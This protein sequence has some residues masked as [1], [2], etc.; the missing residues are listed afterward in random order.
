MNLKRFQFHY[1]TIIS[2]YVVYIIIVFNYPIILELDKFF[3]QSAVHSEIFEHFFYILVFLILFGL[4]FIFIL[5]FG[6]RYLLKPI[7]ILLLLCS[8]SIFYF[9]HTYGVAVDEGV[10]L[11]LFDAL[12]EGNTNEIFDLISVKLLLLIFTLGFIP[13]IPL[14]FTTIIYPSFKKEIITRTGLII[15]TFLVLIGL[16]ASNY[17]DVSLTARQNKQLNQ[18]A[19]PHYSVSSLFS[20][21]KHS[22]QSKPAFATLDEKPKIKNSNEQIIGIVVVGETA[23]ADHFGINGYTKQTTPLLQKTNIIN[24]TNAYSCGTLTKISVPC[25]F[26]LKNYDQFDVNK[27]K[28]Q[29]NLIDVIDASGADITWIENNSSCKNVCDR[30]KNKTIEIITD[31]ENTYDEMMFKFIDTILKNN[32]NPRTLIVLHTMGS[33]GPSY[34]KRYP[35]QFEQFKPSCKSNNPQ[36]C[37]KEELINAYDNTIIYTDYFLH[38]LIERLKK[39]NKKSFLLYASDHGESLGEHGLYLHGV[40][41]KIA[42]KEQIHIPWILWF[43]EQYKKEKLQLVEPTNKITHEYFPH[44]ILDALKIESKY[45]KKEKSLIQ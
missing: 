31:Q 44:T 41:A 45:L 15:S 28:Y 18:S 14:F 6:V 19:I 39:Q 33:H 3:D 4:L 42:P 21:I 34:Y 30:I 24:Y 43:S 23:R 38:Q 35:I 11:S 26:Y 12:I 20:I 36:E 32:R 1:L 17:K 8:S 37:S 25:M 13:S 22:F 9:R 5:L 2:L 16:I 10:I 29:A 7:I 40:P 27:A